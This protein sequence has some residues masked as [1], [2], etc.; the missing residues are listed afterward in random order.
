MSKN[1]NSATRSR[2][3]FGIPMI[4]LLGSFLSLPLATATPDACFVPFT[5]SPFDGAFLSQTQE[6]VDELNSDELVCAPIEEEMGNPEEVGCAECDEIKNAIK[7]ENPELAKE[8]PTDEEYAKESIVGLAKGS[9][10]AVYDELM[11]L[12]DPAEF[13][14][15][16]WTMGKGAV[17][18]GAN[19]VSE[20]ASAIWNATGSALKGE[21]SF[22]HA[23]A[24]HERPTIEKLKAGVKMMVPLIEQGISWFKCAPPLV[25]AKIAAQAISVVG[26]SA[27]FMFLK[28]GLPGALWRSAKGGVQPFEKIASSIQKIAA[29]MRLKFGL[30]RLLKPTS[31]N[32]KRVADPELQA[33]FKLAQS[34]DLTPGGVYVSKADDGSNLVLVERK[35]KILELD[36]DHPKTQKL[37]RLSRESRFHKISSKDRVSWHKAQEEAKRNE[38]QVIKDAQRARNGVHQSLRSRPL[39]KTEKATLKKELDFGK[40]KIAVTEV[41][42]QR[43]VFYKKSGGIF[44]VTGEGAADDLARLRNLETSW[45]LTHRQFYAGLPAPVSTSGL[46]GVRRAVVDRGVRELAQN[47]GKELVER[48]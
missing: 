14:S 10:Q 34:Q 47:D 30:N 22:F 46:N 35:G 15:G 1:T 27:S 16:L 19:L 21:S 36:A 26:L 38:R 23:Y 29:D 44:E 25:Q 32:V 48:F 11:W 7:K 43:R 28:G 45:N 37:T 8:K 9:G 5:S 40:S 24:N 6:T 39:N 12:F 2:L 41:D 18:G 33:K 31:K 42:G 3:F 20:E 4:A 13:F 17:V